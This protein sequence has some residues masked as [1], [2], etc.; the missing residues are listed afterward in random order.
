M[1]LPY[2]AICLGALSP[3]GRVANRGAGVAGLGPLPPLIHCPFGPR[4]S[5]SH[6]AAAPIPSAS[7]TAVPGSLA[8]RACAS[9]PRSVAICARTE[10]ILAR[11]AARLAELVLALAAVDV[12]LAAAALVDALLAAV[13]VAPDAVV[14]RAAA[15]WDRS[16]A[17]SDRRPVICAR[18]LATAWRSPALSL[19][20]ATCW[21]SRLRWACA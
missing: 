17:S 18:I 5:C 8:R 4:V 14:P 10:A 16:V 21:A 9:C 13:L 11:S 19:R 20:A 2:L 3:R 1:P 7:S 6:A 12:F 15:S